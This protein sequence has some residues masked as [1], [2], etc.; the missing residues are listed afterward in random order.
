MRMMPIAGAA[1]LV[2]QVFDTPPERL[3]A[4]FEAQGAKALALRSST[5]AQRVARIKALREALLAQREALYGAFAQDMRKSQAEVEATELI[6][7]L[8][9][10]RHV[11]GDL[12]AWMKPKRVWPTVTTLGLK[13]RIHYQP[14]GRVLII[15]PWNYP[16][17]LCLGPLVCAIGAGN[18]AILK[19]SEMT[20]AVSKLVGKI[21]A[22]VFDPTE[23]TL[24]EG[25]QATSQALLALPFDHIFFTG[26]PAVGKLVMAAAA[27]HLTSVT[28]ELGGKSPS[29]VDESADVAMAAENLMWGKFINS[30][31]TCI[32]PDHVYVH[33]GVKAAFVQACLKA[34][35]KLYGQANER[36]GNRDLTRI[37]NARHTQRLKRILDD[38]T[39]RGARVLVG[40]QVDETSNFVAPTLLE[41]VE[42]D[43]RILQE[44]IFG[45]LLPI[46]EFTDLD[47]VVRQINAGPKPLALYVYSRDSARTERVLRHTSSGGACVNHCV[48][49]Y[50][51]GNLPFGGVNNSG[52][53]NCHGYFGFKAFSH[54]RSV[55]TGGA[56][57]SEKFF[58]PPF[59]PRRLAFIRRIA[60]M[61]RWP[62][63]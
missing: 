14:R 23:V 63:F 27:K 45:P 31:Q 26:S 40:G 17:N 11:I 19:P 5:A 7:V 29:I 25:A 47:A 52:I 1:G 24:F 39:S 18:T 22:A 6:P 13:A 30:G 58:A 55:L 28:L 57:R 9:E 43:S 48:I 10:M 35:D 62:S 61:L 12:K 34:L 50:A 36:A 20:P 59:T 32:A 33:A 2:D 53:G 54:E 3:Q 56:I 4:A 41:G 21:I 15:S 46:L 60:N 51:H 44:E 16:L 37:V 8:D 49:H 42:F 38:A